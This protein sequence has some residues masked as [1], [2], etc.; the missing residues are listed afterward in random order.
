MPSNAPALPAS[1]QGVQKILRSTSGNVQIST[2]EEND[3]RPKIEP[4]D[5]TLRAGP[6]PSVAGPGLRKDQTTVSGRRQQEKVTEDD[7]R[8]FTARQNA[9]Y[10]AYRARQR[11]A[12]LKN[13]TEDVW[14]DELEDAF[15][16]GQSKYH[17]ATSR[18]S[19]CLTAV[20][21]FEQFLR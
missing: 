2:L 7:I 12:K 1:T 21:R 18:L 16:S 3:L 11:R 17:L 8:P 5:G 10:R 20:Q 6:Q 15:Q 14:P 13:R 19:V 4:V 9:R